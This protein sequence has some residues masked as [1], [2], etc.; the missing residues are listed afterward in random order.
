[1]KTRMTSEPSAHG[2]CLVSPI[3]VHHQMHV[4]LRG[5]IGFDC[6]QKLQELSA[7]M[8][9]MQLADDLSGG[10]IQGRAQRRSAMAFVIVRTA[11]AELVES[12]PVGE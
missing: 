1:M 9:P 12:G 8:A 11:T 5:S 2:R 3:V 10:D 4:Q 7:A 6:A